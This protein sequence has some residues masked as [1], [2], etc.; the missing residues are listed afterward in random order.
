M[1]KLGEFMNVL[2][3]ELIADDGRN[4]TRPFLGRHLLRKR[5]VHE[6]F[7]GRAACISKLIPLSDECKHFLT[8]GALLHELMLSLPII[9]FVM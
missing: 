2:F 7:E 5:W 4:A 6:N 3:I 8:L 1:Q 9:D